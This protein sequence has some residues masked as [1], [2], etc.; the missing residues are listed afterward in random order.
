M[1]CV[2][3]RQWEPV[4]GLP[5]LLSPTVPAVPP[6]LTDPPPLCMWPCTRHNSLQLGRLVTAVLNGTAAVA[7]ASLPLSF[8]REP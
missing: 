5:L 7:A 1:R 6:M 8:L 3:L 4:T 2:L